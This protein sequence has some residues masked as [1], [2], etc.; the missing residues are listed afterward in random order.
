MVVRV[1]FDICLKQALI[2]LKNL[3]LLQ[4]LP[5]PSLKVTDIL[6]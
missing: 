5:D 3:M 4:R 1:G 6:T 2:L